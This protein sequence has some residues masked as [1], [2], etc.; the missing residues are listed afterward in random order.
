MSADDGVEACSR[1]NG[2]Y[3]LRFGTGLCIRCTKLADPT[4]GAEI[5]VSMSYLIFDLFLSSALTGI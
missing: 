5:R 4:T 1:C 2:D 3:P